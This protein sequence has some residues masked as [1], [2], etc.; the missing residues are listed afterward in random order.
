MEP[1]LK[2]DVT[3]DPKKPNESVFII[4]KAIKPDWN[5]QHVNIVSTL[6]LPNAKTMAN[7]SNNEKRISICEYVALK[8]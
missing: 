5:L 7:N 1:L 6:H 8:T 2:V 4:L 3:V